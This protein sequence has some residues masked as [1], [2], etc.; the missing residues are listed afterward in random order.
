MWV[1]YMLPA[2]MCVCEC[3]CG[4]VCVS[5]CVCVCECVCV[6]V[7]VCV[8]NILAKINME[9]EWH[10]LEEGHPSNIVTL[11]THVWEGFWQALPVMCTH[12]L[13]LSS[14]ASVLG[15]LAAAV[16]MNFVL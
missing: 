3:V 5:V 8:K 10:E 15:I 13:S 14:T 16:K 4:C 2:L 12:P 6:C 11:T 7:G 9:S 1:Q